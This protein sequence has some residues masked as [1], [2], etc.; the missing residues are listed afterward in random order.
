MYS[1]EHLI[2][3]SKILRQINNPWTRNFEEVRRHK[4][5][6]RKVRNLMGG[7]K[8]QLSIRIVIQ[9]R[10]IARLFVNQRNAKWRSEQV[11]CLVFPVC[12]E[13]KKKQYCYLSNCIIPACNKDALMFNIKNNN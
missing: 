8:L 1:R 9:I 2:V 3:S 4:I 5:I 6:R 11:V 7:V 12:G 13:N 10:T